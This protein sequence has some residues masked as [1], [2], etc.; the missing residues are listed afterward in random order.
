LK[1]LTL[2]SSFHAEHLDDP[3]ATALIQIE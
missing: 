2:L 3:N 1:H